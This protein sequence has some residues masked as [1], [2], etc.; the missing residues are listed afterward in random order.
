MFLG[1]SVDRSSPAIMYLRLRAWMP[2]NAVGASKSATLAAIPEL[3]LRAGAWLFV[4]TF[5]QERLRRFPFLPSRQDMARSVWGG[6]AQRRKT[7]PLRCGC[8][9]GRGVI[10]EAQCPLCSASFR[11]ARCQHSS[12]PS[13]ERD[14]RFELPR[15]LDSVG[16]HGQ[17]RAGLSSAPATGALGSTWMEWRR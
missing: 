2:G 7:P 12:L 11:C 1:W 6:C 9:S 15:R 13:R 4:V 5:A 3:S 16:F 17:L 10:G 14:F 8:F